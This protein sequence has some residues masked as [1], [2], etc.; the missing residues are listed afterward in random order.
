MPPCLLHIGMKRTESLILP[1]IRI[2]LISPIRGIMWSARFPK[3]R[4]ASTFRSIGLL[5]FK[6]WQGAF[7]RRRR[8]TFLPGQR[9]G[10]LFSSGSG[11]GRRLTGSSQGRGL[12]MLLER[13]CGA[14]KRKLPGSSAGRS[15]SSFPDTA[16]R[17]VSGQCKLKESEKGTTVL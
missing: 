7:F 15:M 6:E 4:W 8:R 13:I 12:R 2:I 9:T 1:I 10:R 16:W 14:A 5:I 3:G 11:P 17:S